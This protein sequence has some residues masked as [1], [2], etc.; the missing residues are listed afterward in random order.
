MEDEAVQKLVDTG[1]LSPKDAEKLKGLKPGTFCVHKSWGFGQIAEWNLSGNQVVIDFD[2]KKGHGMQPKYAATSLTPLKEDHILVQRT[3]DPDGFKELAKDEPVELMKKILADHDSKMF[4]DEVSELL[5]PAIFTEKEFK[6]WWDSTKKLL[7]KDGHFIVPPKKTSP[8][9]LREKPLSRSEELI[10]HFKDARQPKQM[11]KTIEE[12]LKNKEEFHEPV[13]ELQP[14]VHSLETHASQQQNL[15]PEVALDFLVARETLID[16]FPD[17]KRG[18]D[19]LEVT[20]LLKSNEEQLGDIIPQLPAARQRRALAEFPNTFGDDWAA[21]LL[22]LVPQCPSRTTSDVHRILRDAGREK[23]L[24]EYLNHAI[25]ANT[26]TSEML[27]WFCKERARLPDEM[28]GPVVL[29]CVLSALEYDQLSE[30]KKGTKLQNLIFDDLELIPDML[31]GAERREAGEVLRRLKMSPAFDDLT[32]R[33]FLGR[34]IKLHPELQSVLTG[35]ENEKSE[36]LVVSWESLEA[37]RAEFKELVEKKIPENSK[38]ISAARELGDLRENFEYKA[39]KQTQA[40]LLRRKAELEEMLDKAQG[41]DFSNPDT[42]KVSIGTTVTLEDPEGSKAE[43]YHILGAWDSDPANHI[44]AYKTAMGL[45][46]LGK[47][48]GEEVD[49]PTEYGQHRQAKIASIEPY[50]KD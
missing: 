33:S 32:K 45:A 1:E 24:Y 23:E 17:L 27:Y 39:A 20:E 28:T 35:A 2:Q 31:E 43:K 3:K 4:A 7:K 9:E 50:K 13:F 6:R 11:L 34:I 47:E 14:I 5:V 30:T 19:T 40:V 16:E 12:I 25:Q 15:R 8:I 38:E 49:L 26:A 46:L 44:I 21:K 29:K 41:T 37:R 18:T 10:K 36:T 42:D 22:N 48:P